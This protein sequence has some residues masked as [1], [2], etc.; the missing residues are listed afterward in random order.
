MICFG[1]MY[2]EGIADFGAQYWVITTLVLDLIGLAFS[3]GYSNIILLPPLES[4]T[5]GG[6]VRTST[7]CIFPSSRVQ[8]LCKFSACLW[9]SMAERR[10]VNS[11]DL[12]WT[13][14]IETTS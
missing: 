13:R 2:S 6:T 11:S 12:Y 1:G 7:A 3:L 10:E 4:I 8:L 14:I 5:R 9:W